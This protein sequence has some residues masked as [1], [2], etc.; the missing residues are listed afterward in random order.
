[1]KNIVTFPRLG[2]NRVQNV[3][4]LPPSDGEEGRVQIN[5]KQYFERV[6]PDIW[7][8]AIGGYRPAEKWLK[9]RKGRSLSF[10]DIEHYG[11]ICAVLR[12]TP[13]LMAEIDK[14][15]DTHGGWPLV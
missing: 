3:R 9:D 1:M 2:D 10:E 4:Y 11:C 13:R 8:F 14:T 6:T 5:H 7:E 15:I 12:E